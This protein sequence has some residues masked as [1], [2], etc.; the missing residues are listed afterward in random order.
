VIDAADRLSP[1]CYEDATGPSH[2]Q[3]IGS[4]G[5]V[6]RIEI[7]GTQVAD[8]AKAHGEHLGDQ[9]ARLKVGTKGLTRGGNPRGQIEAALAPFITD[10]DLPGIRWVARDIKPPIFQQAA[11]LFREGH[12]VRQVAVLLGV[13]RSEA[14]RLRLKAAAEG[15]IAGVEEDE[16]EEVETPVED[17]FRLN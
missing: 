7:V 12:T 14:G 11:E 17:R 6:G 13:S 4:V 16:S 2:L 5:T 10:S 8:C 15:I 3:A 1:E 9:R